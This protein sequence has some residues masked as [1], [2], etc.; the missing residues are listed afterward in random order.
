MYILHSSEEKQFSTLYLGHLNMILS[1]SIPIVLHIA[2]LSEFYASEVMDA[3]RRKK[4]Q[5]TPQKVGYGLCTSTYIYM[6]RQGI[7]S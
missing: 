5:F 2:S 7:E 3:N 4:V 1:I 6:T